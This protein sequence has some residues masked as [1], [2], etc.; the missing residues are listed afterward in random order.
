MHITLTQIDR[1]MLL[2]ALREW[3]RN[4]PSDHPKSEAALA[5]GLRLAE[6]K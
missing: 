6:Q 5:L 2:D 4:R 1:D 3:I